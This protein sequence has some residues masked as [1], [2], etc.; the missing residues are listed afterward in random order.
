MPGAQRLVWQALPL[1][2]TLCS[3]RTWLFQSSRSS[4]LKCHLPRGAFLGHLSGGA[5]PGLPRS[6]SCLFSSQHRLCLK[7]TLSLTFLRLCCLSPVGHVACPWLCPHSEHR[8]GPVGTGRQCRSWQESGGVCAPWGR[9]GDRHG[10]R[11]NRLQSRLFFY[12]FAERRRA[13]PAK[14][15]PLCHPRPA[16][17][18]TLV[19][20]PFR[21][22]RSCE[23]LDHN[24]WGEFPSDVSG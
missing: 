20:Q 12:T 15:A 8:A 6:W 14:A 17:C 2:R 21:A 4:L 16:L 3:K 24:R 11:A 23:I 19:A 22:R 1:P 18:P 13:R 5:P 10:N 7:M 9:A